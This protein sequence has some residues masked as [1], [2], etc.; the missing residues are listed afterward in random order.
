MADDLNDVTDDD[1]V[2]ESSEALHR[3]HWRDEGITRR[4]SRSSPRPTLRPTPIVSSFT[5]DK[6]LTAFTAYAD[7]SPGPSRG[8][9][10]LDTSKRAFWKWFVGGELERLVQLRR[11]PSGGQ[12]NRP[13]IWVP[14][15]RTRRTRPS[16]PGALTSG[17]NGVRGVLKDP[18]AEGGRPDHVPHADGAGCRSRCW[19]AAPARHRSTRRCSPGS[20]HRRRGTG[21][22]TPARRARHGRRLLPQRRLL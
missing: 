19:P 2:S 14:E 3:V 6:S 9:T 21:S 11:P 4:R 10:V 22:R 7:C 13:P 20:P 12:A 5:E 17:V 18:G 16:L 15:R 8:I 1:E